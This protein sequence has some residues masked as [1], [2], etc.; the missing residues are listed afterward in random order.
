MLIWIFPT[1]GGISREVIG[2]GASRN[3]SDKHCKIKR[4][5]IQKQEGYVLHEK[6]YDVEYSIFAVSLWVRRL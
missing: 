3:S 6:N 4:V 5:Y 1:Y 2:E